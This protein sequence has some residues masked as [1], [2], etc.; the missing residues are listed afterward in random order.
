MVA[1]VGS[2][3]KREAVFLSYGFMVVFLTV[4]A[5]ETLSQN[6]PMNTH[7]GLLE[8]N[9]SLLHYCLLSVSTVWPI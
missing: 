1:L 8:G 6:S 3:A 7:T 5:R 2:K 4:L 9:S